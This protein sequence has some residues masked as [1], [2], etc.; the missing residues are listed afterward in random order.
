MVVK[1][2]VH[3][4]ITGHSVAGKIILLLVIS[5][6]WNNKRVMRVIQAVLLK[7]PLVTRQF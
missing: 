2:Y 6:D 5:R 7:Q 3:N 1:E 4:Q